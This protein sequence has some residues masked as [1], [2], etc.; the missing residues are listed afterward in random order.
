MPIGP[1]RMPLMDHLGELRMR[2]VRIVVVLFVALVFFYYASNTVAQFMLEPV[3]GLNLLPMDANGNVQ[4]YTFGAAEAFGVRLKIALWTALVACAPFIIWQIMAFFL[5]AL[6][7]S[8]RKWFIPTFA[9]GCALFIFG[10][11]F[12]YLIIIP[13]AFE[14]LTDQANDFSQIMPQATL[15]IDIILKFELGFGFAF[16]LPLIVFY[17]IVFE[18]V[19]YSKLRSKWREIYVTLLVISG[20]ITPDASPVTML[21]MYAPLIAMYEISMA[22]ARAVMGKRIQEQKEELEEEARLDAEWEEEWADFK[23]RRA[24]QKA[25]RKAAEE[26]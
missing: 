9:V 5:P 6:K 18:I 23:A 4:L 14:W 3:K 16:E 10:A 24:E 20:M 19:P 17:L 11:V 2:F 13:A 15:W 25:K 12:C 26:E 21:L 1:A 8:E 7:P 22:V